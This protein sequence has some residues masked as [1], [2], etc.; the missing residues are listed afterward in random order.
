MTINSEFSMSVV[1]VRCRE[2]AAGSLRW[3]I[4]LDTGLLPDLTV[5]VR[6]DAAN[7]QLLDYY[8]LP[9]LDMTL[10]RL[11]LAKDNGMSLDGYRFDT[12]DA[13]YALTGRIHLLE[14]A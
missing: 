5:A 13:L 10:P 4:C 12:L 9:A 11:R 1:I 8:L 3:H 7:V 14:A 2:T 6:M